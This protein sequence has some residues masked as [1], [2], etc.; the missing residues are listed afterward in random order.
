[1]QSIPHSMAHRGAGATRTN[2]R[3]HPYTPPRCPV[4]GVA[5]PNYALLSSSSLNQQNHHHLNSQESYLITPAPSVYSISP[6]STFSQSPHPLASAL[7]QT[8]PSCLKQTQAQKTQL[9]KANYV[10]SLVDQAVRSLT[11]I[12]RP[13]NIPAVFSTQ[14]DITVVAKQPS[15]LTAPQY[16]T[17]KRPVNQ[18][19]SPRSPSTMPSPLPAFSAEMPPTSSSTSAILPSAFLAEHFGSNASTIVC[20]KDLVPIRTFVQE[21]LRRSR[22]TCSVLQSALCYIEAVRGKVPEL[23]ENEKRGLGAQRELTSDERISKEY[24]DGLKPNFT[25]DSSV[26][27][28]IRTELMSMDP[29]DISDAPTVLQN[30]ASFPSVQSTSNNSHSN[31]K[32]RKIPPKP[33]IPLPPLPSPLLCPR[34]TFLAALIL[35]SKFLQDRCY[36]NRAWAKLSGLPP[37]EVGRCERALGDALGWRLW[38]GKGAPSPRDEKRNIQRTRSEGTVMC[39]PTSTGTQNVTQ[40]L[41]PPLSD[42]GSSPECE[43][44]AGKA[45]VANRALRRAA[46]LPDETAMRSVPPRYRS[47]GSLPFSFA[48]PPIQVIGLS[49]QQC[50]TPSYMTPNLCE[51]SFPLWLAETEQHF[52]APQPSNISYVYGTCN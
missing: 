48:C 21:V 26:L 17:L 46:T 13:E 5:T 23:V 22:T 28:D 37:R 42:A 38:V 43:Q 44:Q 52:L 50:Q 36:S 7:H 3:W 35:A 31:E 12:W 14:T 30:D 8:P 49:Q 15:S 24:T 25:M 18:L 39:G 4:T 19:P 40:F 11:D 2:A 45:V 1:M 6:T 41:S 33:L 20:E 32:R 9:T 47:P 27:N 16:P 34:R 10:A 29:F 51:P